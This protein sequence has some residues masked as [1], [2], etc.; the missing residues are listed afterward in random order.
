MYVLNVPETELYILVELRQLKPFTFRLG[1]GLRYFN[2]RYIGEQIIEHN[3]RIS[4]GS[5]P[6]IRRKM[7]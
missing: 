2:R 7:N 3:R 4:V 5:S 1:E 6:L